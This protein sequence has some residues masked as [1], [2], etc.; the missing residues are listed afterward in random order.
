MLAKWCSANQL[1]GLSDL[2]GC[3]KRTG[4]LRNSDSFAFDVARP[5]ESLRQR[6]RAAGDA[7]AARARCR[8]R[9][10]GL[11]RRSRVPSRQAGQYRALSLGGARLSKPCICAVGSDS[12]LDYLGSHPGMASRRAIAAPTGICIAAPRGASCGTPIASHLPDHPP[13]RTQWP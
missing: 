11:L 3:R 10:A 8:G 13:C 9:C 7:T 4:G 6:L 12:N 5:H 2:G 1:S